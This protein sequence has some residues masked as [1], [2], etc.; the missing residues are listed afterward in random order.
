MYNEFYGLSEKPFELLPDPQF[1]FLTTSHREIIAS[2]MDGI[3]NRRGF[4]SITGEVGTGK[5]TLIRFLLG[6]LEVEEKVKTVFIF[7][8]TITFKELLK[9]ILLELDLEVMNVGKRALLRQLD[10]YL[11]RMISKDE[12]LVVIIDEAQDLSKEVLGELGMLPKLPTLQFVFVGQPEF[13]DK[14]NSQGLRQLKQRIGV[15]GQIRI[16]SE[17]ESEDY[18]DHRLRLVRS[19]SSER[20]APKAISLICSHA[21][22]IPRIINTLCD[23][24]FLMGYSLSKKK[25]DVNIIR[26]VI[27]NRENPFS[28]KPFL[29]SILTAAKEIRLFS[30]R[31]NFLES[32]TVLIVLSFICLGG[33]VLLIDR[34]FQPRPAK[35]WDIQSLKTPSVDTQSSITPPSLPK[36]MKEISGNNTPQ[37]SVEL[38]PISPGFPKPVSPPT[39]PLTLLS[40]EEPFMEIETIKR[41]QTV[42]SLTKKYYSAVNRTLMDLILDSNPEIKDVHL[43]RVDQKIKIPKITEESLIVKTPENTYKINAGTFQTPHPAKIYSDEQ[44]LKGKK[45]EI[46]PRNVSPHE[47]WYQVVIGKFNSEDEVLKM[48]DFLKGKELLPAF[49]G[50]PKIK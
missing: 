45:I 1:L 4:I 19:S 35:T 48:I 22:G 3:R 49:G 8:P 44:T 2:M 36:M 38:K 50:L 34:L 5:T 24:A 20:F 31:L 43:I 27:K 15:K 40:E 41:G 6:K 16:L 47:T 23:N 30:P 33:F 13:E 21:Q 32:K 29:S 28:Q 10:E 46:L 18:I 25:I 17:R 14:L 26:E 12:I 11:A 39:A 42:Y 37:R 7:H 9:N